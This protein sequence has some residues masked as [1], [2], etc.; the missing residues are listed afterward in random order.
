MER[1]SGKAQRGSDQVQ[2]I[3]EAAE[4]Y[5]LNGERAREKVHQRRRNVRSEQ[6]AFRRDRNAERAGKRRKA[7]RTKIG[8]PEVSER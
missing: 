2:A 6:G 8:P 7:E 1:F 4:W 5:G 3:R